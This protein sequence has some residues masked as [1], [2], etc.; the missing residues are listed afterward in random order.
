MRITK[1]RAR[2]IRLGIAVARYQVHVVVLVPLQLEE[3]VS[4][5]TATQPKDSL[6]FRAYVRT[7][8]GI[9]RKN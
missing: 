9:A 4:F 7:L 6:S 8:K 2:R 3:F 5:I 1:G